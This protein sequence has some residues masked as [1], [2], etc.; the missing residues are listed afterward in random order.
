MA[1][2]AKYE[3]VA[4]GDDDEP[5]DFAKMAPDSA[6]PSASSWGRSGGPS[7][8]PRWTACS[9]AGLV[10]LA[11]IAIVVF[12]GLCFMA[13]RY[14][15]RQKISVDWF[16][17]PGSVMREFVEDESWGL[18]PKN[19]S[20]D[21]WVAILP[22][23][24]GFVKHPVMAPEPG[25]LAV[26]HQLHCVN[27]LRHG[28]WAARK[29]LDPAHHAKPEHVRHCF[30]YLRQSLVCLAD[31]NLEAIDADT[32]GTT[33]LGSQRTCRDYDQLEAWADKWVW[34]NPKF[35]NGTSLVHGG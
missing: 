35:R 31:T 19:R 25:V 17:P 1:R 6:S 20:G 3:P 21:P 34:H 4:G 13:G 30:D 22:D 7:R 28:Y 5:T 33:G 15:E 2:G 9:L 24:R 12:G 11:T 8:G 26:Y 16:S 23:G 18:P 10:F 27:I 32:G 14:V 29:K